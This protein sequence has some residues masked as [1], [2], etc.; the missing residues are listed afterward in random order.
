MTPAADAPGEIPQKDRTIV[1]LMH[2]LAPFAFIVPIILWAIKKDESKAIDDQGKEVLNFLITYFI[3]LFGSWILMFV[4]I[5]IL[6]MP[7]VW[8]GGIVLA[9]M[10]AVKSNGGQYY[11]YPFIL[12]LIK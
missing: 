11:R 2:L 6:L 1:M 3:A 4:L 5:G 9:I 12:R 8:I 10:G 7:I